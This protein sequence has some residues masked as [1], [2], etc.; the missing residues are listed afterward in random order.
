MPELTELRLLTELSALRRLADRGLSDEELAR[1]RRLAGAADAFHLGLL[2]LTGDPAVAEIGRYVLAAGRPCAP[3][4]AVR[5]AR[6]HRELA[7][8]VA[9]GM[10]SEAD[11]LLRRHLLAI[12]GG[13]G[14]DR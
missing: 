12:S 9:D 4:G 10:V 13:A 6:E 14:H 11:H 3:A 2:E 7:A 8:M 1:I 5:A